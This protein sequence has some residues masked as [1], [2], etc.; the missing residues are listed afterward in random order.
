[1]KTFTIGRLGVAAILAI[2]AI[3]S[4][5]YAYTP[6]VSQLDFGQRNLDITNLQTFFADNAAIY[7][8]GLVTGY[9]GGLTRS[10]VMRFQAFYGFDQVGRVGPITREK[11]NNL[12]ITGGW[13]LTS[14]DVSGPAFY[15]VT[16]GQNVNS[17]T[18]TFNTNENTMA[19]VVYSTSQLRFN[20]GDINSNGFGAIGGLSANSISAMSTSHSITIPNLQANTLYY[21]TII[22][23]D[24]AGNISVVGP[25][26]TLRT[27]T[28]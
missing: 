12:I 6:I 17:A 4:Q 19:R 26:N 9:F 11:I 10:A 7:P 18:F 14:F 15:N 8:E 3:S 2:T 1:M 24:S 27:N 21:Y 13:T 20:E 25:N 16:R 28:Q 23:S 22:A 5:V